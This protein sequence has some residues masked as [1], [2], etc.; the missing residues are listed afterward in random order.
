M[1]TLRE[2]GFNTINLSEF[3]ISTLDF[4]QGEIRARF[5]EMSKEEKAALAEAAHRGDSRVADLDG[6]TD[7]IFDVLPELFEVFNI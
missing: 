7:W 6:N 1:S 4:G 2:S 3:V 5:G